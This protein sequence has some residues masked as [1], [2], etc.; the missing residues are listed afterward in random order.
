ML[1]SRPWYLT[2]TLL[3]LPL[4]P[5]VMTD[6]AFAEHLSFIDDHIHQIDTEQWFLSYMPLWR[7]P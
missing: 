4:S 2:E 5:P 7:W 1:K 6:I 3:S